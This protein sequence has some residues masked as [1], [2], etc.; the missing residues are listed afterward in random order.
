MD[1]PEGNIDELPDRIDLQT[2]RCTA[3]RTEFEEAFQIALGHIS[4][5]QR[6]VLVLHELHQE[7][8]QEIAE[9][10][11]L[12]YECVKKNFYRGLKKMRILLEPFDR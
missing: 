3:N 5:L 9:T 12:S 10:L 8:F 2:P 7:S 1:V 6:T 11:G 4:P